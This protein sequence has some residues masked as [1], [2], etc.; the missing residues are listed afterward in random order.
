[1]VI[2]K[3]NRF[4]YMKLLFKIEKLYFFAFIREVS[5]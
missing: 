1:M 4:P 2:W 3:E 5:V